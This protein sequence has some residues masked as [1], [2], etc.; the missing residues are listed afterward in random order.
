MFDTKICLKFWEKD[1]INPYVLIKQ[2]TLASPIELRGKGI[3]TGLNL[4]VRILPSDSRKGIYFRRIDLNPVVEIPLDLS[5]VQDSSRCTCLG[6]GDHKILM[7][8]HLLSALYILGVHCAIIEVDGPE[9][10]GLDGSSIEYVNAIESVGLQ[11]LSSVVETLVV[12][13]PVFLTQG[14]VHL[15]AI[16]S[17]DFRVS[18]TLHYPQVKTVG[19]QFFSGVISESFYKTQIAPCR[20]FSIYEEVLPFIEKGII[21][22]GGLDNAIVIKEDKILNPEGLRFS[23]ELVRHKVLDLIGDLSFVGAQIRAHVIAIC[24]GHSTNI[25]FA[26]HLLQTFQLRRSPCLAVL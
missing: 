25:A 7:V 22:G 20:T 12:T 8:E 15:I 3:F 2:K 19:S 5:F 1:L 13:E 4:K 17:N 18:Y 23:D 9:I 26:K 24:S 21:K 14:N 10:P 11:E 16:P 6:V